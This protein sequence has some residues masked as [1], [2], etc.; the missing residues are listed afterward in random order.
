MA[1]TDAGERI[2]LDAT[3][4]GTIQVAL[5]TAAPG[6]SGGGT[7]VTGGSYA[8]QSVTFG[9]AATVT[10]TTTASNTNEVIFPVATADWGTVVAAGVFNGSDLVWYGNLTTSRIVL[11]GDEFRFA[12]GSI[13]L[14]LE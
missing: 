4:T 1:L 12:I 8:R 5:F 14:G 3:L 13:V 11:N 2:A 7:E 6:E 10:G 9:A